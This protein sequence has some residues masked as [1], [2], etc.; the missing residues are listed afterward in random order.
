MNLL[1]THL[2]DRL[3][4]G[5]NFNERV[6]I[7]D[8]A[9]YEHP[10]LTVEHT[11][12]DLKRDSDPI[13]L[14][15][16]NQ[17]VLVYSPTSQGGEPWLYAYVIAVYHVFVYTAA[18]PEPSRL[19]LLWVRWM[20]RHSMQLK[21]PN[22]SQYTR[23]SFTQHTGVPGEDFGFVDPSHVIRGCHLIPAFRLQHTRDR[24]GPS[25]ARDVK[26]DWE[27]FYV[28]QYVFFSSVCKPR[29]FFHV[30][31]DL[32]TVMPLQDFRESALAVS[33]YRLLN[34]QKSLSGPMP[35]IPLRNPPLPLANLMKAYS[36]D[37]TQ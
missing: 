27:A 20:E 16:G 33:S 6:F 2:C 24:L 17:A 26:G 29:H 30:F 4:A 9:L 28:N 18:N 21:G 5:A 34:S 37:A 35:L 36:L 19:E 3:L 13:H 1:Q 23:I 25:I 11:T 32:L 7:K 10:L 8:N 22:S 14:D 31:A 12:Y 15:F